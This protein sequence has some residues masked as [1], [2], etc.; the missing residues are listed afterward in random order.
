MRNTTKNVT[1]EVPV[2]ITNCH[3]SEYRK[4]QPVDA[5][6]IVTAMPAKNAQGEPTMSAATRAHFR[7]AS[8][9]TY[10]RRLEV[11][12]WFIQTK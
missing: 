6:M 4:S 1:T 8:F 7:N 2:L 11:Q 12:Q 5:Q 3:V 9:I 10:A